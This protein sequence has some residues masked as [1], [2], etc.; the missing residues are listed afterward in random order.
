LTYGGGSDGTFVVRSDLAGHRWS[1][2][3]AASVRDA[4]LAADGRPSA[5]S[6]TL[7]ASYGEDQRARAAATGGWVQGKWRGQLTEASVGAPLD[8]RLLEAAAVELD[9]TGARFGPARLALAGATVADMRFETQSGVVSTSGTFDGLRPGDFVVRQQVNMIP[10]GQRDAL[11]L[12]GGW[13]IRAGDLIDGEVNVERAGGDLYAT[14]GNEAPMGVD[15]LRAR[16]T[17]RAN[18]LDVEG[19]LRGTRLGV[20]RGTLSAS[21]ERDREAGWRL[22]QARPWRIDADA[23]LPSIEWINAL[24]SDRVRANVRI[25]GKLTGKLAVAGTPAKPQADGRVEGSELRVAWIEQGV[26]LEN[27]RLALRVDAEMLR[28]E[29][30]RFAGP[31]RVKPND[32]RTAQAM[33]KMQPGFVAASGQVKL[34]DLS[35]FVQVQAERLP[36]LQRVDRWVVATGGA[37]IELAPKRVQ[38]NGA[39]SA[40]AGFVDFTQSDLP[41]LSSDV[42]VV[43]S[44]AAP[45]MRDPRVQVGF[46]LGL[47]LGR[48]FY[49]R[50]SGLDTR[51][52]GAVRLR[53]EGKGIIR[54]SGS[55]NAID[56]VYEG[57]GQKLKIT[58]GRV[59]FQGPP[60]NPGLD[61]LALR[62]GLPAE[63][64]DIG[65]SI[66]RTAANPLIRLFSDPA[67]PDYQALSWL[68]LGRPAEQSGA[69]NVALANAA[70]GLLAGSGE[71][72]P[73]TLARQL[74]IDEIGLRSGQ[75][76]SSTSLLPR[77]SVAGS[78]R[79]DTVGTAGAA[80]AE[81][82]TIGKRVNEA[83]T[84][85]YEQA[86]TG[87][88]NVVQLSYQLSRRLS[89]IAR[90]GTENA[91]DL[92]YTI[93]FD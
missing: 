10:R 44:S 20:L 75:V 89:L 65:V 17:A 61:I 33:A 87:A 76:G 64:G 53:S 29:E 7:Q 62:T 90:A 22:A 80:G 24:L 21:L 49:L 38:L 41:S 28:L 12:R 35:G 30:L 13:R 32:A 36:L 74:G 82:I 47:D 56:G 60:E 1:G 52:A 45:R 88:A 69:D 37:N 2:N 91:L 43:E 93:A 68:V 59:N 8:L 48:A 51:I 81:I 9:G 54:A 23:D 86:L 14:A 11:V 57:Y 15:E 3:P 26:R 92:V 66:T 40:E 55:L 25:G 42:T 27:G 71:G 85:S 4:T 19:V 34:A 70:V 63:A 5:H 16:A 39:V 72:L 73:G 84:I 58:R 6:I 50:G 18:R 31:P 79:G 67:L 46:D 78:L 83:L 77:Q